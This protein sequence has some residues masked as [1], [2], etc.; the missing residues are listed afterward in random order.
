[1]KLDAYGLGLIQLQINLG[2]FPQ[3][4]QFI[5]ISFKNVEKLKHRTVYKDQTI[6]N[7]TFE[8]KLIFYSIKVSIIFNFHDS[9][10]LE[11]NK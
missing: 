5:F 1:M 10:T 4:Q 9:L 3:V 7:L 6:K 11:P 2:R 8:V